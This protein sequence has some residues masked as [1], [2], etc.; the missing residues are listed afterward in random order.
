VSKL[1]KIASLLLISIILGTVYIVELTVSYGVYDPWCDY[2]DDGDI[3][4]Y[5]ATKIA[6]NYGTTGDP[7]KDV[8]VTNLEPAISE[9]VTYSL[10][11]FNI[12]SGM[13]HQFDVPDWNSPILCG[14]YSRLSV[15]FKV[16]LMGEG[17]YELTISL[18]GIHWFNG[19]PGGQYGGPYSYETAKGSN[20][21]VLRDSQG[22]TSNRPNPVLI[23]T[24]APYFTLAFSTSTDSPDWPNI[25]TVIEVIVYLRNE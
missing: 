23:K 13:F 8:T 15:Y 12:T 1:V 24:K 20:I 6:G 10:G 2:D 5:D 18:A 3:D 4:I 17:T 14:G 21:T 11:S 9:Y 22:W 19:V 25:W 7:T 16:E